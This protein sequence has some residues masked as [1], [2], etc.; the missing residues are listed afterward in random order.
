MRQAVDLVSNDHP[1]TPRW[2]ALLGNSL[3]TRFSRLGDKNDLTE[4][5][6]RTQQAVHLLPDHHANKPAFLSLHGNALQTRFDR[7]GDVKDLNAAVLHLQQAVRLAPDDAPDKL[8]MLGNL[9]NSLLVRFHRL[10]DMKDLNDAVLRQQEA[11]DLTPTGD[12]NKP[13]SLTNLGNSLETRFNRLGDVKDLNE[14]VLKEQQAVDLTPDDHP[15]KLAYLFNLGLSLLAQS[16]F[17]QSNSKVTEALDKLS[18]AACSPVGHGSMKF[19]AASIWVQQSQSISHSSTLDAYATGVSLIPQLAWPGS[20]IED[21]HFQIKEVRPFISNASTFAIEIGECTTAVEWFDQGSSIIWSQ[22]LQLQSP[23]DKLKMKYPVQGFELERLSSE[24]TGKPQY[25]MIDVSPSHG[26]TPESSP[27]SVARDLHERAERRESLITEIRE[28]PGFKDFLQPEHHPEL[29]AAATHGPVIILIAND[30]QA[31]ALVLLPGLN[32]DALHIPLPL[33]DNETLE[34]IYSVIKNLIEGFLPNRD[35][36]DDLSH[37]LGIRRKWHQPDPNV[38]EKEFQLILLILWMRIG[39]PIVDGLALTTNHLTR[40][41]WCSTG[42]FSFLPIHAAG[43]YSSDAPIGSKL[44]E[45]AISSYT[46]SVTALLQAQN[47]ISD[48]ARELKVLAIAQPSAEGQNILPGTETEVDY[49]RHHAG[50]V[51]SVQ[52]LK[53]S[54]ATVEQVKAGMRENNWAHFACHGI[55]NGQEPLQSALLLAGSSRLTLND[56]ITMQLSPKGL[57]FLS[58]CQT[59]AGDENLSAEAVHIAAGML[60]AGYRSVIATMWSISDLHAPQVANDVYGFLF[61]DDKND[62]TQA[63]EALHY[64]IKNLREKDK[65]SFATWVPF[66]HVGV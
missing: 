52:T 21:R 19:E 4:A 40:I 58:A 8:A 24:L 62:I 44:A 43:D 6:L 20:L 56:I 35:A 7:L 60:S 15:D 1:D 50:D 38:I 47:L 29:A 42:S 48:E 36:L 13:R 10:G 23:L 12:P 2:L 17:F 39:K 46:P 33:V 30:K 49:I 16:K 57:A 61:K 11:L 28:L 34:A 63:A 53:G 27:Q 3:E 65:V 22:L 55:Q 26:L 66:I 32:E 31:N 37:R 5:V 14:A 45:Y 25:N 9:G 54:V 51:V 41:W 64:A 18:A 59:A